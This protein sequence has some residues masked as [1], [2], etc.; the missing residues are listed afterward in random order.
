MKKRMITLALVM[1]MLIGLSL[2]ASAAGTSTVKA[3]ITYRGISIVVNGAEIA[4]CDENGNP[5]EPFIMNSTTYLPVRAIANAL[6][7]GV[8]WIPATSTIALTRG[9]EVNYGSG[10]PAA[11]NAAK[12]VDITYRGTNISL[13]GKALPLVNGNGQSVEPFIM[14]GT[15]YLPLRIVGEALGLTV[16]W[17][18]ATSTVTL[19]SKAAEKVWV[20]AGMRF[21]GGVTGGSYSELIDVKYEYD[22]VGRLTAMYSTDGRIELRCSYDKNGSVTQ[23]D[24]RVPGVKTAYKWEYDAEGEPTAFYENG[25]LVEAYSCETDSEG[26]IVKEYIT[27]NGWSKVN[28]YTYDEKGR[29]ASEKLGDYSGLVFEYSYDE[30]DRVVKRYER[31]VNFPEGGAEYTFTYDEKGNLIREEQFNHYMGYAEYTREYSYDTLGRLAEEVRTW[32]APYGAENAMRTSSKNVYSYEYD[33][34]G[35]V[36]TYEECTYFN[37]LFDGGVSFYLYELIRESYSYDAEGRLLSARFYGEPPGDAFTEDEQ[38]YYSYNAA[39][40]LTEEKY[41]EICGGDKLLESVYKYSYD[42][43]GR[44]TYESFDE[45]TLVNGSRNYRQSYSYN[46][47]GEPAGSSYTDSEG[48][49]LYEQYLYDHLGRMV[50]YTVTENGAATRTTVQYNDEDLPVRMETVSYGEGVTVITE[51]SYVLQPKAE[52]DSFL[53]ALVEQIENML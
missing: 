4:P 28:E 51:M 7:L 16:Q 9:G 6:G 5:T 40:L 37:E 47:K 39:G 35:N 13:D 33:Q 32:F 26:R 30:Y 34:Y 14:E 8:E 12:T 21:T 23:L 19:S 27:E 36:K 31:D 24:Y 20:P 11:S 52:M 53:A 25:T 18:A 41:I 44:L 3:E 50:S 22:A 43:A 15:N 45:T 1:L 49:S 10:E 42:A 48:N 2:P 46:A 29:I 17:D 38:Y